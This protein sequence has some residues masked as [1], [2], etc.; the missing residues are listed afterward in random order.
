LDVKGART[1]LMGTILPGVLELLRIYGGEMPSFEVPEFST[2]VTQ[3]KDWIG[4]VGIVYDDATEGEAI[5]SLMLWSSYMRFKLGVPAG[6]SN[7]IPASLVAEYKASRFA[8]KC[9]YGISV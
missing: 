6:T 2:A 1:L 7:A 3:L 4:S 8:C 5:A 9:C